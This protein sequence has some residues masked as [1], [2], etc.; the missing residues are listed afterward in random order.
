MFLKQAGFKERDVSFVPCSGLSGVNLT[1]TSTNPDLNK[2]YKGP[3]LLEVIGTI[4]NFY[5]Q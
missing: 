2:W 3:T 5:L 1:E 4:Q